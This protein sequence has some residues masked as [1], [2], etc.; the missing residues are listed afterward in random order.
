M[1]ETG[2]AFG[3]TDEE[4]RWILA[5]QRGSKEAAQRIAEQYRNLII[6]MSNRF[7]VGIQGAFLREELV[8]AGYVG[9]FQAMAHYSPHKGVT[10]GT[11]AFSWILGEMRRAMKTAADHTGSYESI[12]QIR[13]YQEEFETQNGREATVMEV[14]QGCDMP[15][16]QTANLMNL[17]LEG[18]FEEETASD[19]Y[20]VAS[21]QRELHDIVEW[22]IALE[23]LPAME[24][25][26]VLLRYFRD[27]SQKE[28]ARILG[29]SQAQVS[30]VERQALER[31][32]SLLTE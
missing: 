16:W 20:Q 22:N 21:C 24:K 26:L 12:R 11:Y 8:Q 28:T 10:L 17:C 27:L 29:K 23:Q 25:R 6:K 3:K 7:Q 9:L 32:K 5:A 30:R 31:L 2:A 4:M 14:S 1:N 18:R 19:I 13:R 15:L